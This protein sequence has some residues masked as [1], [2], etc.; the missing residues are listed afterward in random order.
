M[1][2]IELEG[3]NYSQI[4]A[5]LVKAIQELNQKVN[6]QHQTINSLINR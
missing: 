6:E 3:V 5:P 2:K 4:V 1:K